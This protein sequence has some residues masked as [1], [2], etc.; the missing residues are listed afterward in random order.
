M[1]QSTELGFPQHTGK[2][3]V[4]AEVCGRERSERGRVERGRLSNGSDHLPSSI[5]DQRCSRVGFAKEP[6][7]N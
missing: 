3:I 7:E 5:H 2:L 4:G 1:E 6:A